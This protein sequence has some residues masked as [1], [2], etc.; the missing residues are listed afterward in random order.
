MRIESLLTSMNFS[1]NDGKYLPVLKNPPILKGFESK[2]FSINQK[3][4]K[5][6]KEKITNTLIKKDWDDKYYSNLKDEAKI[7]IRVPP[8]FLY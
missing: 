3:D 6:K 1:E 8:N 2:L 4:K 5:S 7:A